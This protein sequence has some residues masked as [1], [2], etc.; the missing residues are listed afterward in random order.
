MICK[1][2]EWMLK[3]IKSQG[4][5]VAEQLYL[6][7]L[8]SNDEMKEKIIIK[9]SNILLKIM[10]NSSPCQSNTNNKNTKQDYR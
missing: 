1:S 10:Q 7:M 5:I 3:F 8:K 2:N 4:D 6:I 9:L